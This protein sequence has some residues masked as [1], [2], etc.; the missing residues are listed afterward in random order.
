MAHSSARVRVLVVSLT[1]QP[2][3]IFVLTLTAEWR[4]PYHAPLA[5]LSSASFTVSCPRLSF[6]A[7]DYWG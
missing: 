1:L 2:P 4:V 6:T 7:D 3:P 5:F